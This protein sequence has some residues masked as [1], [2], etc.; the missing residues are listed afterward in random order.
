LLLRIAYVFSLV[1]ALVLDLA[2]LLTWGVLPSTLI[3]SNPHAA[4]QSDSDRFQELRALIEKE[5]GT[6]TATE[7]TQCKL[8]PFGAK[9]CGGPAR[10]LVYST[11]RTDEA[12]LKQLVNEFNQLSKK[13]NQENKLLS[14]CMYVA[15]PKIEFARGV[16][17]IAPQEFRRAE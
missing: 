6:P 16:C 15:E 10:Y 2:I 14:D 9:P 1:I 8:I 5:I 12:R 4:E 13:I 7:A 17:T 11:A 3:G